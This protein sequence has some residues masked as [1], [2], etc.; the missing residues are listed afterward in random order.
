M[1]EHGTE[2]KNCG[3]THLSRRKGA[4]FLMS[5]ALAALTSAFAG[6][7]AKAGWRSCSVSGCPCQQF[8]G[9]ENLCQNC[10]HQYSEHW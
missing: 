10:G 2:C 3:K 6:K 5:A 7:Q 1:S 4:K 9:Y 8:T